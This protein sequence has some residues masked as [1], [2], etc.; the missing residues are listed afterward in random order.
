MNRGGKR[1]GAGRKPSDPLLLR[2]PVAYRLPRPMVEWM[3]AQDI[4]ATQIIE[5][6]IWEKYRMDLTFIAA[7]KPNYEE[8][9]K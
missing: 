4:P 6:A 8:E 9:R 3:R 7:M 1:K 2:V 5:N